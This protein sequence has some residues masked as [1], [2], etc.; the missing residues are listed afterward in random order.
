M[1]TK[2]TSGTWY[3]RP[4]MISPGPASSV[5]KDPA[6]RCAS[7][8]IDRVVREWAG[9]DGQ[10][11]VQPEL[12]QV[13]GRT[14]LGGMEYTMPKFSAFQPTPETSGDFEEMCLPAGDSAD[15][16]DHECRRSGA[17]HRGGRGPHFCGSG[18]PFVPQ[19]RIDLWRR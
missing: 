14:S 16:S 5:R 8:A 6:R 7:S 1:H 17:G 2:N 11:R 3:R 12:P 18:N 4:R 9:R 15:E 10:T 13:I 19:T